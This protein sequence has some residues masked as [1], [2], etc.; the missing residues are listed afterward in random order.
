MSE[1]A[2]LP[3]LEAR[4]VT[5]RFGGLTA[6]NAVSATFARGELVGIIGPNGAGKTT[7]FNAISGVVAPSSGHLIAQGHQLTGRGPH[8]YAAHGTEGSSPHH[9]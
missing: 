5:V 1:A 6:V 3:L 4:D 9:T 8:R 2:S 7:F